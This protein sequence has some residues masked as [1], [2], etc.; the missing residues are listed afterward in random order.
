MKSSKRMNRTRL[1]ALLLCLWAAVSWT[2]PLAAL[3]QEEEI[4][5][6]VGWYESPF[7]RTDAFGRRSGYAYEYQ[8]KIAAYTGWRYEYVY[9]SWPD[10]LQMLIDGRI[11]LMS[12]I[13]YTVGRARSMLFSM[14][15]MG[16]EDYY[17]FVSNARDSGIH[18]DDLSSLNG[19][20][21]GINK[22]S[23]QADMFRSWASKKGVQADIAELTASE[24]ETVAMLERGELD[25]LVAIDGFG[26]GDTLLPLIKLGSSDCY[27]AVS[28]ARPELLRELDAA[29]L[30]IQEENAYYIQ[31]LQ[32]KYFGYSGSTMYLSESE[33]NW[34]SAHG[35]IRVGYRDDYLAFCATDKATGELTGA[36]KEFLSLGSHCIQNAEIPFEA[37]PF[38]STSDALE[39]LKK[40]DVDCVFP[41]NFSVYDA[42]ETG[43]LVT[44]P[45]MQS[46]MYAVARSSSLRDFT[47][48]GEV[49]VAVNEGNPSYEAFL[50]D[51]FP[52][53]ARVYAQ[54]IAACLK[55]VAEGRAD[56]VIVSNYRINSISDLLD[57]Y[58]LSTVT[59]GVA[60]NSHFAISRQS[61]ALYAILNK[62]INLVP[63]PA[64]NAAL[65]S[66]SYGEQQI[67]FSKFIRENILSVLAFVCVILAAILTLLL[68]SLRSE[69]KTREALGKIAELN[70]EQ[71]KQLDEIAL[72]NTTL[73][74]NQQKLKE[75][76]E[77]SEQAS[78]AKTSFLSNMSHEIRTP[79]NA[80][81]GLDN[82]ALR[83]QNLTPH[84]REQLEKIGASA[85]HLL[86]IIN[87][88]LDMSRIESG[89]M[90]LKEEEFSFRDFLDQIN[91]MINGQCV[92]KGL[93]F[94]CNIIGHTEDY[95]I[96]D[97]MKLKQVLIN[98]LG[99]AVKFTPAPGSVTFSVE[100]IKR[101]EH[102]CM[103]RFIIRDTGVG[104]SKEFIPKIFD[105]FSQENDGSG[106]KY[107]STG[108]GMAIT[109]SIVSMMNGE[110][111]VDSEKG[112]GTT[113]TVTVTL[114]MS[115]RSA[116]KDHAEL[117]PKGMRALVVD[118]DP[119]AREH[120]QLVAGSVGIQTDTVKSG[121]EAL[122]MIR[123]KRDAGQPYQL[124]LTDCVMPGMDG[125]E[126]TRRL[127]A[128]DGRETAV[129]LL[130]GYSWEDKLN[131]ALKAGVD[132]ISSKPLFKDSLIHS[133][134]NILLQRD[135]AAEG[136]SGQEQSG[137][138]Q[139]AH[140]LAGRRVLVVEDMELNA[141][142]LMDLLEMEEMEAEHA[143]N[144]QIAVQ[145]FSG[146][147]AGYYDAIL[148]D[149]RMPVMNGLEATRAI[150]GLE[151]AD[152]REIPIIAMTA[153][154]FDEDVQH[155]LQAGMDAHLSK[156]VEPER[157]CETLERMIHSRE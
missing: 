31:Q 99:N 91:V 60:M 24:A 143:E 80:I 66:Y 115:G 96:G 6:R 103:C 94:E 38:A 88:I 124:V 25:A 82:I 76:L 29:M 149:V 150:R 110:I 49:R 23:V 65:A 81:I 44:V 13:S 100:Q 129:I 108:L 45:L 95:Y 39:A 9:G 30:R 73:S 62:V 145:M 17:V 69:R 27:F 26:G 72:L 153:N 36:L 37:V 98:I 43:V 97:D 64:V 32:E 109:K 77:A 78:R 28:K 34:L 41:V 87:D 11:D 68:R 22:G 40:G 154:A 67:T 136:S 5:V 137:E 155:S 54:D 55:A 151:R 1:A 135:K 101:F 12:D 63:T 79:M 106:N 7:N 71:K 84:T 85:K 119:V 105:A 75:A 127:R 133:I 128:F 89:R 86:G 19:K 56:C 139:R 70:E 21:F 8:Q 157:L 144:G 147:P 134:Q 74:D 83:D 132:S 42:E 93:R 120:E 46:E 114:K 131:E 140:I 90:A 113:F 122:K 35:T 52:N 33:T 47:M 53:W 14:V 148:M 10:L 104:M 59:T 50:M 51:H 141:E 138:E 92:D 121:E 112:A 57:Q 18:A 48:D 152:A 20:T 3:A 125:I 102:H 61:S 123:E 116:Q 58:N 142:I 146:H 117:I 111:A 118:D 16:S 4:T 156:P 15:P 130:T 126:F 107:G 2:V